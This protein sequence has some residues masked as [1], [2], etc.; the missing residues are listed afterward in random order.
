MA[1]HLLK[2]ENKVKFAGSN[3][4]EP[5][6]FIAACAG[7]KFWLAGYLFEFDHDNIWY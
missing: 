7:L 5:A 3:A 6:L 2:V 1:M 4:S